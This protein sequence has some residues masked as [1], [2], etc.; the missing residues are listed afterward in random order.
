M[1]MYPCLPFSQLHLRR[2]YM[3]APRLPGTSPDHPMTFPIPAQNLP[4]GVQSGAE[5]GG[6]RCRGD[7]R[8]E[9]QMGVD[10]KTRG[11]G[12]LEF[13]NSGPSSPLFPLAVITGLQAVW[14]LITSHN[15]HSPTYNG[16]GVHLLRSDKGW[17]S[18]AGRANDL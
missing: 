12:K 8:G 18:S 7:F 5:E 3:H 17:R 14:S 9:C 15:G 1:G 2:I 4:R 16:A 13:W 11:S 10:R 6:A